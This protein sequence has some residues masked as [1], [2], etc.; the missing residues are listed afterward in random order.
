MPYAN[1]VTVIADGKEYRGCGGEPASLL[2]GGE[3]VADAI[4]GDRLVENSRATLQFGTDGRVSGSSSC[5]TYS[6]Q[7]TLTGEGLKVSNPVATLKACAP[8]LMQQ[9]KFMEIL[10]RVERFEIDSDGALVLRAGEGHS[11]RARR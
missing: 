7:Y 4:N 10:R 6:G 2:Q 8:L 11:I 3:W 1:T 5:N 9:D